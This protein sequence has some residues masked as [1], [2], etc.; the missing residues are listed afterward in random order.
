MNNSVG[1]LL[2]GGS[3]EQLP[4]IIDNFETCF[5]INWYKE[6]DKLGKYLLGKNVIQ[7]NNLKHNALLPKE[8]YAKFNITNVT[9]PYCKSMLTQKSVAECFERLI[10]RLKENGIKEINFLPEEYIK[11]LEPRPRN[12]GLT[13]IFYASQV[14]KAKEIWIIGLDFYSVGPIY[15]V[16]ESK[17]IPGRFKSIRKKMIKRFTKYVK[18]FPS[19]QYNIVS[20][21]REF[22]KLD[23]LNVL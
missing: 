19:V 7:Y 18:A 17:D 6:Y 22:P 14:L 4:T 10:E 1:I 2:R 23:N 20:Y 21:H 3:L 9:V 13:C 8:M 16:R 15:M 12:S 5:V 11:E